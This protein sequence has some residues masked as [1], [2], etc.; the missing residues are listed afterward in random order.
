ML[1]LQHCIIQSKLGNK[2]SQHS[3]INTDIFKYW[4]IALH[5]IKPFARQKAIIKFKLII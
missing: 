5:D 1:S 3:T 4:T 2:L